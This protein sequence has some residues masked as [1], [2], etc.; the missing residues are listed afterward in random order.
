MFLS[1]IIT[2]KRF[3]IINFFFMFLLATL[4]FFQ[5]DTLTKD[6]EHLSSNQKRLTELQNLKAVGFSNI[7]LEIERLA[8][9]Y[10]FEKIGQI[11]Y[12]KAN[13]TTALAK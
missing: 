13:K 9:N 4:W 10:N 12:I 11:Y 1:K 2:L 3:L 6:A 5:I 8:Q 7:N